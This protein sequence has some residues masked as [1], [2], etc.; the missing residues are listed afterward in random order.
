VVSVMVLKARISNHRA[1]INKYPMV[2][3]KAYWT[4]YVNGLYDVSMIR[5]DDF[6]D[7]ELYIS[8]LE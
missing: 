2:Q 1:S 7:L 8:E 5:Y 3:R 6:K 4:G